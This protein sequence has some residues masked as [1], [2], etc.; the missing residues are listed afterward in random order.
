MVLLG[1]GGGNGGGHLMDK[2]ALIG[3]H[4]G[5]IVSQGL[6]NCMPIHYVDYLGLLAVVWNILG[7]TVYLRFPSQIHKYCLRFDSLTDNTDYEFT[8]L[9]AA[10]AFGLII[11][12]PSVAVKRQTAS[13]VFKSF[14]VPTDLNLPSTPYVFL[15][16]L[17]MSQYALSGFDASAHMVS[18]RSYHSNRIQNHIVPTVSTTLKS[19]F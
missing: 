7:E 11:L 6:L 4:G 1:T 14:N 16:G 10:G 9:S 15:L 18:A 3:I 13:F 8:N 17:L 2:Y 5:L 19:I 12:I